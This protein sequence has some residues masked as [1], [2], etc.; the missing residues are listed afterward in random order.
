MTNLSNEALTVLNALRKSQEGITVKADKTVWGM[1]YLDNAR[2]NGMTA[3]SFAGYLSALDRA[4]LYKTAS[5]NDFGSV[6][7]A[8]IV[9]VEQDDFEL[10]L[11]E[12]EPC[13]EDPDASKADAAIIARRNRR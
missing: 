11:G 13:P 3:H 4:G 2:P 10:D 9:P 1:V 6:L 7:M 12:W 8:P 5:D